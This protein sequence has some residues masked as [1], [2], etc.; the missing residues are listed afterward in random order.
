MLVNASRA[1]RNQMAISIKA[2]QD[3]PIKDGAGPLAI[4]QKVLG[5]CSQRLEQ[6]RNVRVTPTDQNYFSLLVRTQLSSQVSR[7]S[8]AK[9]RVDFQICCLC[10]C[11]HR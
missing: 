8:V 3:D 9:M 4:W 1:S 11:F 2:Q 5:I 6:S 7:L 10:K